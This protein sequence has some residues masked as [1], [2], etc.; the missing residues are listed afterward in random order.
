MTRRAGRSNEAPL[1]A[2][3]PDWRGELVASPHLCPTPIDAAYYDDLVERIP[4]AVIRDSRVLSDFGGMCINLNAGE[5]L[6][7]ELLEGPQIVNL[8]ALNAEDPDERLWLQTI[9]R[10]G[11]FLNRF[12]RL[13]GTMARYRPLLTLLED[14]VATRPSDLRFSRHHPIY[15]GA[16]T[17][18]HWRA[19]GGAAHVNSTWTQFAR[20]MVELAVP[21][22]MLKEDV[23]LFQK[24]ALDGPTQRL[25]IAPSDALAGDR[26]VFFSEINLHV[27]LALSPY[28]DGSARPADIGDP[29]PLPAAI[30]TSDKVAEPLLWP[31]PSVPYPDLSPYLDSDGVRSSE[32]LASPIS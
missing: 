15:G 28:L 16:G 7:I 27:L 4:G 1:N 12:T 31:Y 2:R 25:I 10:E 29:Q 5:L 32:I 17:Q 9:V 13:W 19:A 22:F 3:D 6:T 21:P 23:C 26:V 8:F 20:L 18:A 30:T 11:L 14:T 24:S